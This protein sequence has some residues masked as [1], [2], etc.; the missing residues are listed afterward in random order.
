MMAFVYVLIL[1]ATVTIVDCLRLSNIDAGGRDHKVPLLTNSIPE[2]PPL[3][4][5]TDTVQ[6]VPN[7]MMNQLAGFHP[8]KRDLKRKKLLRI[9]GDYNR[10]YMSISK[11]VHTLHMSSAQ[12]LDEKL[13]EDFKQ[14][15]LTYI[16]DKANEMQHLI[17]ENITNLFQDWLLGL[18][19]CPVHYE[20]EDLGVL[21]WPRWIKKGLC[22]TEYSC[23]WPPG[24]HCVPAESRMVYLLRW[25]CVSAQHRRRSGKRRRNRKE[26]GS[27]GKSKSIRSKGYGRL[28]CKWLK[29]PYPLTDECFCSC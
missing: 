1:C 29:V 2:V 6:V 7:P 23:S 11:P 5:G 28:K 15:N 20:W 13:L 4:M 16:A 12:Q 21:F 3:F 8:R 22:K 17:S 24:M 9:L 18:A 19:S 10:K 26:N 25:H 27:K 14:L